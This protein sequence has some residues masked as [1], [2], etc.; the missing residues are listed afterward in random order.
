MPWNMPRRYGPIPSMRWDPHPEPTRSHD[1]CGVIYVSTTVATVVAEVFQDRRVIDITTDNPVLLPWVPTR[2]LRLLNL[3]EGWTL[4]NGA[5]HSL[6]YED[7]ATCRS[8]ARAIY[9]RWED[10]DGLRTDSTMT[11]KANIVL[12]DRTVS[13][14]PTSPT[15][16]RPLAHPEL[17]VLL[18]EVAAEIGYTVL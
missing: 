12:F 9:H 8:W 15:T 5:A 17:V 10:L 1:S 4:R 3:T 7:K 16:M 11:G 14:I 13:A 2:P 18:A 6:M